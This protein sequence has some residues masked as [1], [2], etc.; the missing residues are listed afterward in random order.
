MNVLEEAF[1][2]QASEADEPEVEVY[3]FWK[4]H[5]SGPGLRSA[6]LR[7][8]LPLHSF[9]QARARLGTAC[10]PGAQSRA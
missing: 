9:S 6:A 8:P 10:H 5:Y 2:V 7:P 4:R 1:G 3:R